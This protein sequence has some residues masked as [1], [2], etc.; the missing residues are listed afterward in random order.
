[1]T[2]RKGKTKSILDASID[3]ALLAVEIYNKPR[4]TFRSEGFITMMIMAWTRLFHAHFN[5]TIGDKYYYKKRNNRYDKIDGERKA[6]E[7]STCINKYGL[8]ST[9]VESNLNFF[10]KLRNKIEHRHIEK[11][12][13]D[14]LIFGECQSLL[15]NYES[16]LISFFGDSY[17]INEALVYSLQFSQ[18][19]TQNQ[20]RANRSALSKDLSEIVSFIINYRNT[21]DD[22]TYNSQEY[23]IKLIQIPKI[24]NT[25]RAD[26]AVEFVRWDALNDE[27]KAAYDQLNVII[28]DKT[29]KIEAANVGK[30]KPSEVIKKVNIALQGKFITLSL[31]ATLYKLFNIRP[32]NGAE[33]PFETYAEFCL[34]DEVHNDYVYQEA[35][36]LFLVHFLQTSGFEAKDLR[37]KERAG[38]KLNIVDFRM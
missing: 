1:M 7:L 8:L 35:W 22:D 10:I 14:T 30:L 26:V 25:N 13:V 20:E 17:S 34:Y 15:F 23:S 37:D 31:H 4:T 24:S 33:D 38:D 19:R 36:V 6:W 27:D 28:K 9:G 21:L 2:L 3:S 18:I 12:E 5:N 16:A 29:V 11:R 32:A